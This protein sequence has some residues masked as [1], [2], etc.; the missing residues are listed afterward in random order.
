VKRVAIG[1]F[2]HE[3]NTF[4]PIITDIEDFL[5]FRGEEIYAKSDAYLLAKGIIEFFRYKPDYTLSP[6]IFARA[7]PNGEVNAEL[8]RSL[9]AEFFAMLAQGD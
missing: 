5:I 7:V 3:S 1:G 4:N 8:Y 9:K 6:L 2:F